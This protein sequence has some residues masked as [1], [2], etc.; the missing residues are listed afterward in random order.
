MQDGKDIPAEEAGQW[1]RQNNP[2]I[3]ITWETAEEHDEDAYRRLLKLLF[4]PG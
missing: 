2:D 1:L 4:S 3:R